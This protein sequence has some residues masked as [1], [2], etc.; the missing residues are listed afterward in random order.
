M[1][2]I[3]INKATGIEEYIT[4]LQMLI[5][6]VPANNSLTVENIPPHAVIQIL[7]I[8]GQLIKTLVANDGKTNIDI[9]NLARGVYIVEAKTENVIEVKKFV[10]E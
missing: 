10:K 2:F 6:P 5:Y 3:H 9:S 8:Q 1:S 4:A 7:N